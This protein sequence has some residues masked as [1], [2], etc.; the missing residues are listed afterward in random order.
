[1]EYLRP[2]QCYSC[3]E[4]CNHFRNE[5]PTKDNPICSRCGG[6]GHNYTE[7]SKPYNCTNCHRSHSATAR[8]CPAYSY[9]IEK[10]KPTIA[11]QLAHLLNNNSNHATG[12]DILRAATLDSNNS[13]DFL[14]SLFN[15]CQ[16]FTNNNPSQS[17]SNF[18]LDESIANSSFNI[19]EEI[20]T[21]DTSLEEVA[22]TLNN[23]ISLA[24]ATAM[25]ELPKTSE[26]ISY[27]AA[28]SN[29]IP[30]YN[31]CQYAVT[32]NG[33]EL[34]ESI[35][36]QKAQHAQ[37]SLKSPKHKETLPN[38]VYL[39][40]APYKNIIFCN[41][42]NNQKIGIKPEIIEKLILSKSTIKFDTFDYGM[43]ELTIYQEYEYPSSTAKKLA[44]WLKAQYGLNLIIN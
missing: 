36:D 5:C 32:N 39:Q 18:D 41:P 28:L 16:I 31:E 22:E 33:V 4:W 38:I 9:A 30:R 42:H 15:A 19:P 20:I 11:A 17:L 3:F 10:I 27:P 6:Y 24:T 7:C 12:T 14:T 29:N 44:L 1:M 25:A 8:I 35:N 2:I 23:E 37:C 21:K 13:N 40:I 43:Y 26:Y 34:I